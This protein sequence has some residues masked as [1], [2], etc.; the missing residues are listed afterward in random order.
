[1]DKANA[2]KNAPLGE[3]PL[4]ALQH[5]DILKAADL[6]RTNHLILN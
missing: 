4:G 1:M 3:L 2:K 5:V 6:K